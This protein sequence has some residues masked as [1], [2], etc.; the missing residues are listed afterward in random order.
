MRQVARMKVLVIILKVKI[1]RIPVKVMKK[2][3]QI[4][5]HSSV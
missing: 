2:N 3:L 1:K 4:Q 5:L